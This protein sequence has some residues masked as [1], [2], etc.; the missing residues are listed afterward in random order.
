MNE[1]PRP[2][3]RRPGGLDEAL[4]REIDEALGGKSIEELIDDAAP[5]AEAAKGPARGPVQPGDIVPCRV[6]AIDRDAVLVEMGGKDQGMVAL[7]QFE[8]DPTP[9]DVLQL[10]VVRYDRSE[11]LWVVSRAGAVERA[12]WEDLSV[13]MMVEALVERANKGGLEVSFNSINA[14]MPIS[15]ISMY[16]VEKPEEFVGQKLKCLVTE[17]KRRERRV[18]VSARAP[19]E[20]EAEEKKE[21]LLAELAE[22]DIRDG[23]VRQVVPFGAFVDLGGVD[24]LVHV[25]Q[26]SY[27]RVENPAD[28][29][30]PGQQVKVQVLKI[31]LEKGRISL[32]MKQTQ[33]DPWETVEA[34]YSAGSVVTVRVV[35]LEAFGAFVE[36]E[37]GLEGLIPISEMTWTSR[38]NHASD[39]LE[40]GQVVKPLVLQVDQPRRRISLSLKQAQANPW[41]GA[42][43]KF[44]AGSELVGKV[45]RIAEFGAFVELEPGVEGLVHISELSDAHVRRVE[46]VAQIGQTVTVRV[47]DVDEAAR[48]ISLTMKGVYATAGEAPAEA[49]PKKKRKRPLRGGLD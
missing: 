18:I 12:T 16:R 8:E 40:V 33:P 38:P 44:P 34:N 3:Q 28:L 11:D 6:V 25:S 10:E 21:A 31:D 13:G 26:M 35:K 36:L 23:V 9:G 15:Q 7:E 30:Q 37:P 27:T 4:Q 32:G 43:G 2:E 5:T 19:M 41:A 1:Q 45:T 39:V 42:A 46:E 49:T 47:R 29:V 48:R 20:A 22:G 17:V 14:F 24:G